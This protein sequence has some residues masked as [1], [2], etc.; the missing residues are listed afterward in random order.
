MYIYIQ[1]EEKEEKKIRL[2]KKKDGTWLILRLK[3]ISGL[4]VCTRAEDRLSVIR[5]L[6]PEVDS[7]LIP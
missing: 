2:R 7:F 3:V 6:R 5:I 4:T 1:A